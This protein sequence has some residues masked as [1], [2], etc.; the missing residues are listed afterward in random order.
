MLPNLIPQSQ[1]LEKIFRKKNIKPLNKIDKEVFKEFFNTLKEGE[2]YVDALKHANMLNGTLKKVESINTIGGRY[3]PNHIKSYVESNITHLLTYKAK[4]YSREI[5]INFG[6]FGEPNIDELDFYDENIEFIFLWLYFC[7]EYALD[8]CTKQLTANLYLTNFK[9]KLPENRTAIIGAENVNTAFTTRCIPDG[10]IVLF[11]EEE[12]KKVFIH[13]TIHTYGLDLGHHESKIKDSIEK[14]FQVKSDFRTTEAYTETWARIMNSCVYSFLSSNNI[15]EKLFMSRLKIALDI[16]RYY[17]VYQTVKVL[18]HMGL[19]YDDLI[20]DTEKS[21]KLR[22]V[23][24]KEGTHVLNY[25]VITSILLSDYSE[26]IAMCKKNNQPSSIIRFNS[27]DYNLKH[28]VKL[29]KKLR[30]GL[31]MR[32]LIRDVTLK[33]KKHRGHLRNSLRMSAIGFYL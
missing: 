17:S 7:G 28:F 25:Y 5:T 13:E 16:E 31:N 12:W 27:S 19:T 15:S 14:L 18:H 10:V 24:Y 1:E 30:D 22:E 23:M 29:I 8:T 9:K 3:F 4:I 2:D 33:F 6:I 20:N 11:R 26:F 32:A 21:K